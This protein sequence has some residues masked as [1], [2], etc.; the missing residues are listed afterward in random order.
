[1]A[2][3]QNS[4]QLEPQLPTVLLL[5]FCDSQRYV[6]ILSTA[7]NAQLNR[8]PDLLWI[9]Y[10]LQVRR[11]GQRLVPEGEHN[12]A[13]HKSALL[14]RTTWLECDHQQSSASARRWNIGRL[15]WLQSHAQKAT[16]DPALL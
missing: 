6:A 7:Q 14:R 15:D 3:Q 8:L 13:N 11:I 12:V 16:R 4:I 5:P 9:E 2:W 10:C 1:D